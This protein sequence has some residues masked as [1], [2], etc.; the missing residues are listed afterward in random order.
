MGKLIRLNFKTGAKEYL[1]DAPKYSVKVANKIVRMYLDSDGF[2]GLD[3][4]INDQVPETRRNKHEA[5]FDEYYDN[6]TAKIN[7]VKQLTEGN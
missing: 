1:P 4:F 7:K 2:D 5:L 6:C 3:Y